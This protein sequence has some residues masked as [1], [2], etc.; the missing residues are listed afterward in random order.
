MGRVSTWAGITY[1][2]T[3]AKDRKVVSASKRYYFADDS[4]K[5]DVVSA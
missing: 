5:D 4:W 3:L 1:A 2:M